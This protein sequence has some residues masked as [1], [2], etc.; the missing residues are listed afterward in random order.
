MAAAESG[1]MLGPL[2]AV[3]VHVDDMD[4][5]TAFYRDVLGLEAQNES[6][7][8]TTFRTGPCTLALHAGGRIGAANVRPTFAVDDLDKVVE[9]LRHRGIECSEVREPTEG[10]RVVDLRDPEGN[11]LSLEER[12][13]SAEAQ[14]RPSRQTQ[15][16]SSPPRHDERS[17]Q[18]QTASTTYPSSRSS[19]F[20]SATERLV[21]RA[22]GAQRTWSDQRGP[23]ETTRPEGQ[24]TSWFAGIV[25][26]TL[27][28][29]ARWSDQLG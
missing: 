13:S 21:P 19:F 16:E 14:P 20:H 17:N 26:E 23:L 10:V 3:I 5:E 11:V 7:W 2:T 15:I 6:A 18:P 22:T 9:R 8:W 4:V 25:E 1:L 27:H 28:S 29:R 12:R 24:P